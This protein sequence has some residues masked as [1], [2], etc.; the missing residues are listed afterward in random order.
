MSDIRAIELFLYDEASLLDRP[1]L[2][3][4][5]NLFTDDGMYWM[6]ASED[7]PDALNHISHIYD[8]KVMME[9]RRRNFVHP[10]ASS[11][12]WPIRCSH[13]IGNI[14]VTET[15]DNGDLVV[16]SNQ[17]V[18]GFYRDEQRL[19]A[20]R[21]THTLRP[22]ERSFRIVQKKVELINPDSPQRSFVIYL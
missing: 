2:D 10:A 7:Q 13:V 17:H 1:D 15:L 6:P 20:Y 3:S 11:K 8:D 16:T 12:D 22:S 19:Y 5:M 21:G 14:R 18:V 4:W 9:I